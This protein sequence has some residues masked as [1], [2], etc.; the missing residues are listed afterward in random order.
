MICKNIIAEKWISIEQQD[1]S[2]KKL[3][4]GRKPYK[5]SSV[6]IPPTCTMSYNAL[7]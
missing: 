7:S 5:L 1:I 4:R 3:S 6:Y 2:S